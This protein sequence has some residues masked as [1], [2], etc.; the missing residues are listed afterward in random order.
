MGADY[1]G[2]EK[3]IDK[4]RRHLSEEEKQVLSHHLRNALSGTSG[5]FNPDSTR[6]RRRRPGIW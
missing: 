3:A 5:A 1:D 2:Q 6:W 4:L